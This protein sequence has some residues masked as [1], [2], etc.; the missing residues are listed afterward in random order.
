MAFDLP[1]LITEIAFTAD[2]T[3]EQWTDVSADVMKRQPVTIDPG[4]PTSNT[5]VTTTQF[6]LR[7]TSRKYDPLHTSF[8]NLGPQNRVRHLARAA[9]ASV[10]D[11]FTGADGATPTGWT[12]VSAPGAGASAQINANRYRFVSGTTTYG[13]ARARLSAAVPVDLDVQLT[14]NIAALSEQYPAIFV[15]GSTTWSSDNLNSSYAVELHVGSNLLVIYRIDGAGGQTQI[16]SG[17]VTWTA[18][19]WNVR[20]RA[21]GSLIQAKA[22]TGTEPATWTAEV[23]DATHT[24]TALG[25]GFTGGNNTVS[26]TVYFD[27]LT[28]RQVWPLFFGYIDGWPQDYDRG[29]TQATVSVTATDAL[30][31]LDVVNLKSAVDELLDTVTVRHRYLLDE[32][33]DGTV[34]DLSGGKDGQVTDTGVEFGGDPLT[35]FHDGSVMFDGTGQVQIP[36]TF[37]NEITAY[38]VSFLFRTPQ[39]ASSTPVGVNTLA[40]PSDPLSPTGLTSTIDPTNNELDWFLNAAGSTPIRS[41][42]FPTSPAN[43]RTHHVLLIR[44]D[45]VVDIWLDGVHVVDSFASGEGTNLHPFPSKIQVGNYLTTTFVGEVADLIV[46]T[47]AL[48]DDQASELAT[49]YLTGFADDTAAQRIARILDYA[50]WPGE[51]NLEAGDARCAP[52]TLE[53]GAVAQLRTV[54]DTEQGRL[55]A[56]PYGRITL[57]TRT[58]NVTAARSTSLQATFSDDA[59]AMTSTGATDIPIH[60]GGLRFDYDWRS[61]VAEATVSSPALP[62]DVTYADAAAKAR[63]GRLAPQATSIATVARSAGEARLIGQYVVDRSSTAR[64]RSDGWTVSLRRKA[65]ALATILGLQ[66]GDRVRLER[67]PQG[68]GSQIQQTQFLERIGHTIT[69]DEWHVHFAGSPAEPEASTVYWV[70][71]TSALGTDTRLHY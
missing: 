62:S 12:D 34:A 5:G 60:T 56:D 31:A 20:V 30:G 69:G 14:V 21:V 45:D 17:A 6:T 59:A 58:H 37:L 3:T 55:F 25:L 32:A 48:S 61:V 71:G 8:A 43:N 2:L 41:T 68:V 70:L 66:V 49:A 28:V 35:I 63:Y 47:T 67:T 50:Q 38:S 7:N 23:R 51:T 44:N 54:A 29:N 16:A 9:T 24:G 65:A 42:S 11:T 57:H 39:Q 4:D 27:D 46:F 1:D 53:G 15:R 22:W 26:D 10:T 13:Y 64:M 33:T 40:H 36:E 19:T 18:A 52:D